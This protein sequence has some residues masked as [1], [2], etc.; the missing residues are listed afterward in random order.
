MTHSAVHYPAAHAGATDQLKVAWYM[1]QV[2]G[3]KDC[4][5]IV[6]SGDNFYPKVSLVTRNDVELG[7]HQ[8]LHCFTDVH[9]ISDSSEGRDGTAGVQTWSTSAVSSN[10][11]RWPSAARV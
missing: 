11:L 10:V 9:C 6:S 4:E 5:F 2:C 7:L 8:I 3:I 1:N